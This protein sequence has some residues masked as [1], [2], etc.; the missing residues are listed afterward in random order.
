M[1]SVDGKFNPFNGGGCNRR[2]ANNTHNRGLNRRA[3]LVEIAAARLCGLVRPLLRLRQLQRGFF[4]AAF[5]SGGLRG[6]LRRAVLRLGQAFGG[7]RGL[8]IG[9]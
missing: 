8:L 3:H 6:T 7:L 2:R 4:G 9:F 1:R 5:S